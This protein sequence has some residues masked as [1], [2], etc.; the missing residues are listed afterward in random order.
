MDSNGVLNRIRAKYFRENIFST[1]PTSYKTVEFREIV[2]LLAIVG[3]GIILGTIILLAEKFYFIYINAMK[4]KRNKIS[5]KEINLNVDLEMKV[6]KSLQYSVKRGII[7]N[8]LK[9]K[10]SH[11][12]VRTPILKL[13][14][15]HK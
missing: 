1:K 2:L 4:N 5:V 8:F 7:L 9:I 14:K 6:T 11:R 15:S 12:V 13:L 10:Y 3:G